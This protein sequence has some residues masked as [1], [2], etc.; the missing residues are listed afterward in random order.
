MGPLELGIVVGAST[1]VPTIK[2]AFSAR[3]W[4]AT[5][6]TDAGESEAMNANADDLESAE[7]EHDDGTGTALLF[8]GAFGLGLVLGS[9]LG[10]LIGNLVLGIG[11]G[12]LAG[13]VL[14]TLVVVR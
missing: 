3:D 10:I 8:G 7:S 12:F 13:V 4:S 1:A 2:R 5:V 11:I 9:G 14:G 6:L